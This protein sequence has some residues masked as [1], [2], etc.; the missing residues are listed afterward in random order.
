MLKK[1]NKSKCVFMCHVSC[2]KSSLRVEAKNG[3]SVVTLGESVL[4]IVRM[5]LEASEVLFIYSMI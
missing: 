1:F 3:F 4:G 5:Y 2:I